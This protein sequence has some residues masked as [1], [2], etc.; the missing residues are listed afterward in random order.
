MIQKGKDFYKKHERWAPIA[1]FVAGFI[2]DALMLRRID[3]LMTILQQA[4]YIL[5]IGVLLS[6][7]LIEGTRE[8]IAPR[9]LTKVWRYREPLLHFLMGTLLNAY[10][11][12][13]FKS[14]SAIT[15]FIFIFLLVG[16]LV[17]NEFKRFGKDQTKVHMAF[18][19][20]CLIS[21]LVALAPIILG[22]IG[23]IPFLVANGAASLVMALYVKITK[24]KLIQTPGL[25]RSHVIQPFLAIQIIFAG[26]Y[27]AH[28]IP[29]VPLSVIYMGVYHDVKKE[30][31]EYQLG[32]T[33]SKFKFWQHGDQ[34]F[35]ARPG[36]V[37][38]CFARIFSPTRFRDQI[39]VRWLYHDERLG[40]KPSDAIPLTIAGGREEGFRGVTK[41]SNYTPGEWRVQVETKDGQEIGR[42]GFNVEIDD[43]TDPR[44][45][46]VR[47][48]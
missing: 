32:Y 37:I 21:Y 25:L 5:I 8:V 40:W 13:Y 42:I 28:A 12:F 22:F 39:Q 1:F 47:T 29:P 7:E 18:F 23:I 19:S 41:K 3:E 24:P 45:I 38:Y 15:S 48:E 2:F 43:S 10:T 20:L 6:V 17:I 14:A 4:L 31:G 9:V 33:R 27:F 30:G 35:S 16:L 36:D 44:D 34:S 11:I 46:K 26:L